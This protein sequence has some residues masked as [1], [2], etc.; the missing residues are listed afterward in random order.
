M[1]GICALI[2]ARAG[3]KGV[4]D[5]NIRT[6]AGHPLLAWSIRAALLAREVD[7]VI[8]STDSDEYAG[9]ARSYGADVPFLRPADASSD[10]AGDEAVAGHLVQ[11]LIEAN[12][13]VPDSIVYLRPT[14]PLR[15]PDVIDAAVASFSSENR[16]TALRSVHEMSESAYK[17]FEVKDG[18]LACVGSGS[19][20]LDAA[21]GPRQGFPATWIGNGYVDVFRS[22]R[23]V[24][25][26][27]LYG[28]QVVAFE[29]DIAPEIDTESDFDFLTYQVSQNENLVKLLF[30][31]NYLYEKDTS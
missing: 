21:S 26:Q 15:R 23:L 6:L 8:V 27:P 1:T 9:I 19:T 11:H 29:T 4:P 5:K 20:D 30:N 16:A 17:T 28:D 10:K 13:P 22:K 25:G 24:D 2:P 14:T 7:R 18:V 12:E 31:N 3:S